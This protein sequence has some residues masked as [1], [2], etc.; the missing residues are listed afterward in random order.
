MKTIR[1]AND[2]REEWLATRRGRITGSRIK[3]VFSTSGVTKEMICEWL[4]DH[5][6]T[7][8]KAMKREELEALLPAEAMAE[9]RSRAPKKIGFYE[10][11][12]EKLGL[13]PD[14]DE[15]Q[16]E[17]GTRLEKDA[18]ARFSEE[19]GIE[20]DTSLL[21]WAREDDENIAVSPDGVIGETEA[22]EAKCLSSANH[23]KA[24]IERRIPDDYVLQ[25]L[26]YFVV[27]DQL[28]KLHFI[29]FDPRFLMF[30]DPEGKQAKID[31][32]EIT[33]TRAQ[34]EAQAERVD[35]MLAYQRDTMRQVNY[36]VNKLSL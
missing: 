25:A 32:F 22:V 34:A 8:K 30:S 17:R 14:T 18:I 21:I 2:E 13:P 10:L 3:N 5:G 28:E 26:Q 27:N 9:L 4:D 20:V 24:F 31:Y 19:T 36:W 7:Y 35:E 15:N 12:A 33:L 29:F 23:I 16:M 11:I 6:I 1:F